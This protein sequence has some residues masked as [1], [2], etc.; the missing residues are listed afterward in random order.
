[1]DARFAL[2][3]VIVASIIATSA[4]ARPR[5]IA[6]GLTSTSFVMVPVLVN[7]R[8]PHHFVIDTGATTTTL[9]NE[10]AS[11]LGLEAS[12]ALRMVTAGGGFTAPT[13]IVDELMIG[14]LRVT[15][16][17]V[18]WMSLAELRREEGRIAGVIGQDILRRHTLTI[19]YRRRRVR[20]END[21][22]VP[23][24]TGVDVAWA[25]DRPMIAVHLRAPG[26][27]P[28]AQL[29]L[30]SAANGLVLFAELRPSGG[31]ATTLVGTHRGSTPGQVVSNVVVTAGGLQ[32]HGPAVLVTPSAPR[33]ENGL[34]PASWFS[35]V[36]IDGRRSH[37]T[38]T[39]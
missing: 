14:V 38:L 15:S 36:C 26:L 37:A 2:P 35:R 28:D 33:D 31:A 16:V 3:A 23:G 7:G 4:L 5:E 10:L 27:R 32:T 19:D 20:L 17:R 1:M 24:D 9:D 22:C 8:G 29:V 11:V 25:D 39:R 6:A 13:G 30:D 21:A 12:G 18:S 34:L